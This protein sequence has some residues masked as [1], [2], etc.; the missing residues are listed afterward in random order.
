M[1]MSTWIILADEVGVFLGQGCE[2]PEKLY[3]IQWGTR[4]S[5]E[6][7]RLHTPLAKGT[8]NQWPC[9]LALQEL[10]RG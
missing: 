2:S 3:R 4:K 1:L 5:L 9:S 10:S 7:R 8:R 6:L